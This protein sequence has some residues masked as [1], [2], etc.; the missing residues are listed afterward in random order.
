[1]NRK[2]RIQ[3]FIS[4]IDEEVEAFFESGRKKRIAL[5]F[6]HKR[7]DLSFNPDVIDALQEILKTELELLE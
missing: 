1:M 7:I 6:G 4:Y 3:Q 5:R 2:E